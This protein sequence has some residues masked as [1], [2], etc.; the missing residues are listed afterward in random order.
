MDN[1]I[2]SK[3]YWT[4]LD[5]ECFFVMFRLAILSEI[6]SKCYNFQVNIQKELS[7]SPV[8]RIQCTVLF[9][10]ISDPCFVI[11][12][13]LQIYTGFPATY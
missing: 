10:T 4:L 5:L 2:N 13:R 12:E 11:L 7:I 1:P 9:G 8:Q 6:Y 3:Y